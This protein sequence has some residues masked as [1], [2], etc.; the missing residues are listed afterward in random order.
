MDKEPKVKTILVSQPQPENGKSIFDDV[1]A[2]YKLKVDF[3]SFIQ[4]DAVAGK[5]LRKKKLNILEHTAVIF[6]SKNAVDHFFRVVD[7]LR[8]ELPPDM[9][10]FCMSENIGLYIQKYTVMRKRKVFFPKVSTENDFLNLIMV[11]KNEKYL[12]PCSDIRRNAIPDFFEKNNLKLTES[13]MYRTVS[14]DLSD[15][16]NVFYDII[17]FFSPAD[18]KSLFDNFPNFSQNKTRIAAFGDTTQKALAE[19]NLFCN[20]PAPA[21]GTP[22]IA[23]AIEAYV[24]KSNS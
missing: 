14:A 23:S 4:V 20:I 13:I 7:E 3:R 12:F 19:A 22:S 6:N 10:Y 2:K 21:P 11:H 5:D 15:L 1:A 16:E 18:I 9:K 17:V 8:V 24:K